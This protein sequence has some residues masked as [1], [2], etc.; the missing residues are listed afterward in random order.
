MSLASEYATRM[1]ASDSE[2]DQATATKPPDFRWGLF[3]ASVTTKG[4]L[5]MA[6]EIELPADQAVAFAQ[7]ATATFV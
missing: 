2:H 1:A 7:C 5:L 4:G 3:T 6:P